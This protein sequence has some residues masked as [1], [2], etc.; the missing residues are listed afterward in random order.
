MTTETTMRNPLLSTALLAP[1][2]L[3]PALAAKERA[4]IDEPE[5]PVPSS[6]QERELWKERP[7][8]MPPWPEEGD[9]VEFTLDQPSPFR[10]YIDRR[11][12]DVG[13]DGVV[14]F[15]LVAASASGARNV[16]FEGLRCTPRGAYKVY[17]YGIGGQFKPVP[18]EDWQDIHTLP[19]GELYRELHGHFLCVPRA[20]TPRPKKDMVRAL[21]GHISPRQNSGFLTD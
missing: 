5:A 12:L 13:S 1:L 9:L 8:D 7:G 19:G 15:T 6:V 17:A 3:Q 2:L 10:Y 4:F 11:S 21:E 16:S 20:F 14:R 18:G